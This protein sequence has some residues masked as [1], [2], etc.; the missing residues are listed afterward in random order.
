M[1]GHSAVAGLAFALTA[2]AFAIAAQSSL[3]GRYAFYQAPTAAE[4]TRG[5]RNDNDCRQYLASDLYIPD[6]TEHLTIAGN[7]WDENQDVSAVTGNIVRQVTKG[8]F[9][10]FTIDV[11]SEGG[12]GVATGTVTRIGKLAIT[13]SVDSEQGLRVLHYCKV[14]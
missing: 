14:F 2:P 7:R 6:F 12:G 13:I 1:K 5:P 11:E 10:Y 9:T 4:Q 3:D 8:D